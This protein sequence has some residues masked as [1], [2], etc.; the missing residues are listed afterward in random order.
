MELFVSNQSTKINLN[1]FFCMPEKAPIVKEYKRAGSFFGAKGTRVLRLLT[2]ALTIGTFLSF[3]LIS[4]G[5][6]YYCLLYVPFDESHGDNVF[7]SVMV[8]VTFHLVVP[9]ILLQKPG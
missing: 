4:L 3:L 2:T 8:N 5:A 9:E 6:G 7:S 1:I